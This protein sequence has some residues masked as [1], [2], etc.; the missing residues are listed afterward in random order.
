MP[1]LASYPEWN[2]S[3]PMYP[4]RSLS[5]LVPQMDSNALDLLSV[6]NEGVFEL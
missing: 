5:E 3:Y 2:A 1:K 4:R 6:E